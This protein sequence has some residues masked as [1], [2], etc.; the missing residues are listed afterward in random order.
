MA[1]FE[2]FTPAFDPATGDVLIA[3][4]TYAAGAPKLQKAMF[5]LATPLGKYLPDKSVGLNYAIAKKPRA[6][7]VPAWKAEV[8]RALEPMTKPREIVE[9]QVDVMLN[10]DPRRPGILFYAVSFVDPLDPERAR[11][12]TPTLTVL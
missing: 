6:G 2:S 4:A 12:R 3:G 10:V 11:L 9:L 8:S 7:L 5:L 1:T